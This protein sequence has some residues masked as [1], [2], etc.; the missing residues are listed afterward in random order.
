MLRDLQF[1]K[2][3]FMKQKLDEKR[4]DVRSLWDVLN[5]GEDE[6]RKLV[7]LESHPSD[8]TYETYFRELLN[9]I[10]RLQRERHLMDPFLKASEQ[11]E[12]AR[13]HQ[14]EFE[15]MTRSS[16]RL[17]DKNAKP[18][19]RLEEEKERKRM[20]KQVTNLEAQLRTQLHELEVLCKHSDPSFYGKVKFFL[21]VFFSVVNFMFF[22]SLHFGLFLGC[23]NRK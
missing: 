21:A 14:N 3:R 16:Q 20:A 9:E 22:I 2:E 7:D 4:N 23:K 10:Q 5:Y 19:A 18:G 17:L 8:E 11:L 13:I 12:Q 6:R 15:V 1:Q